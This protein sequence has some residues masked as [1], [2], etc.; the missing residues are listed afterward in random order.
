MMEVVS[1]GRRELVH[2]R[3]AET[4]YINNSKHESVP[5]GSLYS[6]FVL[7]AHMHSISRISIIRI[8]FNHIAPH[9]YSGAYPFSFPGLQSAARK[10][11]IAPFDVRSSLKGRKN[12]LKF[13][14]APLPSYSGTRMSESLCRCTF[15]SRFKFLAT[16]LYLLHLIIKSNFGRLLKKWLKEVNFHI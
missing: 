9:T 7:T 13:H 8:Q 1:A 3:T 14:V 11:K 2:R 10:A 15:F 12:Q 16:K 4:N 5:T 6:V